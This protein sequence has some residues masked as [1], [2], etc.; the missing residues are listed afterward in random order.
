VS[1]ALDLTGRVALVTG[2]SGVV[3]SGIA[4]RLAH[5]GASVAIHYRTGGEAARALA[6]ELG[7][8]TAIFEAD[9]VAP[10][11]PDRLLDAVLE[12]FG[13][14]DVL[15]NNAGIQPVGDLADLDDRQWQEM[16][17]TDLTSV[18]RLTARAA[19][20]MPSG[21][22][23]VHIASIEGS[24]PA[25]GHGH[26]AAAK[27]GVIMHARAAAQEWGAKGIRVN[28]VSPGLIRRP[29]IETDWPEGVGRWERSAPLGRL[30]TGEDVG[31]A[32]AF[33]VSDL[34]GWVTG[35]DL[36]VDGGVSTRPTW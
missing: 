13:R 25:P 36:V 33:L 27:A 32:V 18:H 34:A 14:L 20:R 4:R 21:A 2:A 16:I 15:V 19:A 17:D 30:G 29:G 8:R 22:S 1:I 12:R 10:E 28:T 9:L 35:I 26:Y 24:Q 3:G 31:D 5:A 23:I 7:D 11:G 6:V